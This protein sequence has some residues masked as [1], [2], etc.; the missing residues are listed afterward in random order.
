M[1]QEALVQIKDILAMNVCDVG[2][3]AV[4][5]QPGEDD[6]ERPVAFYFKKRNK[7]QAYS[8]TERNA[9]VLVLGM[10]HFEVYVANADKI[11]AGIEYMAFWGTSGERAE[12]Q[13]N[14]SGFGV[15]S[16]F[17]SC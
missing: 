7:H 13:S 11:V 17:F 15:K 1:C 6:C 5:L 10:N 16:A 14:S 4:L 3:R 8:T 9:S 12:S 2:I